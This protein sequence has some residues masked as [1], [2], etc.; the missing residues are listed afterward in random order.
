MTTWEERVK[1]VAREIEHYLQAH[2]QAADSWEGIATWWVSRQRIREEV[3]L[4]RAALEK[5]LEK[6]VVVTVK[7]NGEDDDQGSVYRLNVKAN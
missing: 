6:E 3:A 5:L 7:G 1:A 2:P 4:V